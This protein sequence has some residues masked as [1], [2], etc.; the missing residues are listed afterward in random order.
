MLAAD[1]IDHLKAVPAV[2]AINHGLKPLAR[3]AAMALLS[4]VVLIRNPSSIDID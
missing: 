1:F 4:A 2:A 3:S